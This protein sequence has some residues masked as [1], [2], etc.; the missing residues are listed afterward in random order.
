M[1]AQGEKLKGTEVTI[2]QRLRWAAGSNPHLN[3]AIDET[4]QRQKKRESIIEVDR[5]RLL[6]NIHNTRMF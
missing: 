4:E 1:K 5:K 2:V 3:E 6:A